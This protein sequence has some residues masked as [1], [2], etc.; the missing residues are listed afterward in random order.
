MNTASAVSPLIVSR[1]IGSH[2]NT[3]ISGFLT[4][5]SNFFQFLQGFLPPL[6]FPLSFE[7]FSL[8]YYFPEKVLFQKFDAAHLEN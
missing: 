7:I 3:L 6:S 1:D 8:P 4:N 2:Y 5:I